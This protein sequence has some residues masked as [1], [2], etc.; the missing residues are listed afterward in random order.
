MRLTKGY[1]EYSW[2]LAFDPLP[3]HG[4]RKRCSRD[5]EALLDK[6]TKKLLS[7]CKQPQKVNGPKSGFQTDADPEVQKNAVPQLTSRSWSTISLTLN[8]VWLATCMYTTFTRHCLCVVC[9]YTY[10]YIYKACLMYL[11]MVEKTYSRHWLPDPTLAV[12]SK[13]L[14]PSDDLQ[15]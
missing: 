9:I 11:Y 14:A 4:K 7:L 6:E 3:H 12:T 5:S 15:A 1:D 10:I 13:P 8:I 2:L